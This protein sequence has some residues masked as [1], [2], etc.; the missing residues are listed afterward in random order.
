MQVRVFRNLNR[1]AWSIQTRTQG[2]WR[3][4]AH[5]AAVMVND[6]AFNASEACRVRC[7][8][9]QVREVH[10][11]IQGELAAVV[12]CTLVAKWSNDS[13]VAAIADSTTVSI[14]DL[15]RGVTYRPFVESDFRVRET[16]EIVKRA[17]HAVCS[18]PKGCTIA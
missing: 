10:A 16:G 2:A 17:P 8:A 4:I 5:A 14:V 15:P 3:T 1:A 11:W 13:I 18:I 7:A 6:A 9:K 12:D